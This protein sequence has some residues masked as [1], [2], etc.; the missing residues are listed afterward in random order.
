VTEGCFH[1]ITAARRHCLGALHASKIPILADKGYRGGGTIHAPLHNPWGTTRQNRATPNL[2]ADNKTYNL[3][4][5]GL[6]C[7]GERAIAI[8][9]TRWRALRK[10]SLCPWRITA[11]TA[12]ALALTHHEHNRKLLNPTT[13]KR[14]MS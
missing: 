12:A 13:D 1:D 11:I 2:T 14:S 9:K 6:R 3:L 10:V 5:A 8:L 7:H 4:L